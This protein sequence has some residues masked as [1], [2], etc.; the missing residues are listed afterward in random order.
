MSE[1]KSEDEDS[2]LKKIIHIIVK[3]TAFDP[4]IKSEWQ[5]TLII[6]SVWTS[7]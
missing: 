4:D 7:N 5:S 1:E 2:F 3:D 6:K